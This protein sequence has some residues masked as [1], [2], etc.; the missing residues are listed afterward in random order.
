MKN[1]LYRI[2]SVMLMVTLA[3]GATQAQT[4][5]KNAAHKSQPKAA[6]QAKQQSKNNRVHVLPAKSVAK[7]PF[8]KAAK[9][10]VAKNLNPKKSAPAYAAAN[11]VPAING[12]CIFASDW[13]QDNPAPGL[14]ELPRNASASA[15]L[16]IS[17][18]SGSYG[19]VEVDGY[20]YSTDYLDYGFLAFAVLTVYDMETGEA[21]ASNYPSSLDCLSMAQAKDPVSGTIYGITYNSDAT[22]VQLSTLEY[23]EDATVTVTK[24]ADLDGHWSCMGI[25]SNSQIYAVRYEYTTGVTNS[26]LCK[27]DKSSGTVTEVGACGVDSEYLGGATIDPKTNRMYWAV[28]P[29]DE[30]GNLYE[31]NL[32]TGAATK[33]YQFNNDAE[34]VSLYIPAPAAEPGA[35]A[36]CSNVAANFLNGGLSGNI[37][38]TA[39]ATLFD[40]SAA[41]GNVTIHVLANDQE[42]ATQ[43]AAVGAEVTIPVTM[44]QAGNYNFVVYASNT[45]GDGPK[46]KIKNVFVGTDTPAATTATLAYEN[47][48]MNVS[49]TAV[50]SSVNGGYIDLSSLTYTV[51]DASGNVK[52]SNLTGTSWSEDYAMPDN[53]EVVYYTVTVV[54]G[55]I[56]S[57]PAQTNTVTVG[58]AVPPYTSNFGQDGL[59][60]WTVIDANGDGT[61]W[62][63][64][65]NEATIGYNA[66]LAM[67]DWLISVP[68]KLEAGKSYAV[69]F[70]ANSYA[71]SYPERLEV[72]YGTTPT[73]SGMTNSLIAA[74]D[75]ATAEPMALDAALVPAADG[76]YYIGIH[77]ISD[78]DEWT[79][80]VGNLTIE[81]GI[82]GTAPGAP[83]DL[84]VTPDASG[85]L[86]AA[87]SFKAPALTMAGNTLTELSKIEVYRD[88]TL[89]N[90]FDNPTIGGALSCE[91]N[92]LTTDGSHTYQVVGYN[93]SGAG[94]KA[95]ATV[96]IGFAEPADM[97]TV[98]ISRTDVE[99]EVLLS[100]DAVTTDIN[101]MAYPAGKVTYTVY[102]MDGYVRT[103]IANGV[104]ATSYTFQAVNAGEQTFVQYAVCAVVDEV[105]GALNLSELIPV[106]TPYDGLEESFANA[107]LNY[108]WATYSIDGGSFEIL[109]DESGIPAQDGDNGCVAVTAQYLDQGAELISGM[110]S[111]NKM[112]NPGLSFY[113]FDIATI[114]EDDNPDINEITVFVKAIDD[115]AYTTMF[116]GTVEDICAGSSDGWG[117][118]SVDLSQFANKVIE[119]KIQGIVQS[120]S[121]I[122]FD[123]IKVASTLDNDLSAASI[124][125]PSKVKAGGDFKVDVTVVNEGSSTAAEYSVELYKDEVLVNTYAGK[126]L[127]S[128]KR[129]VVS[130]DQTLSPLATEDVTY[131]AKV[132]FAADENETNN[133]TA[134]VTVTPVVSNYPTATDLS[135]QAED[136]GISLTWTAPDL[137]GGVA[138]PV[139]FDFEDA[140]SF[141]AEYGDFI[142]VDG[143]KSEVGGFE[144]M[145][146]PGIT[147]GTT[148]GSFWIWDTDEVGTGN[149]TFAAHSGTHYLFSLFRWDSGKSDEWAITPE[150]DGSAQDITFYAKSYSPGY[151]ES[152]EVY[153]ST[154][155]TETS[156]FV[157]IEGG[158][159]VPGDWTLYTVSVPE[160]AKRFAIRSVAEDSFMLMIDD[161]TCTPADAVAN[162][163]VEGYNI[164]RDGEKLN[165]APVADTNY[166][167]N[168][169][170]YGETYTYV[171][172]VVYKEKGESAASN[173][174]TI[175]QTGLDEVSAAVKV[176]VEGHNIVVSNADAVRVVAANG[177][178][179]YNGKGNDK[180]SVPV[181][182]GV[183]VVN[184]DK[185]VVKVIVK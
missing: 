67:D 27:I 99:G 55:G 52:A 137:T 16:L 153:Y 64:N 33:L 89:I 80:Y 13:T 82:Y 91:D 17:G 129:Q 30:T 139:T 29:A 63:V 115:E 96:Y 68:V 69:S 169:V 163:E 106:G 18:I 109:T 46:T 86:K 150:L 34:Y 147:A 37:T 61:S 105:E 12:V 44:A 50:N 117:R 84:V 72:K 158:G 148:L 118:V 78:A 70:D 160:G 102:A 145:D 176:A 22:G 39:P 116:N 60:G 42:I 5:K 108:D 65:G 141:T 131:Y 155:S 90:T 74:T 135:A 53:L 144:N 177:A 23:S 24:I 172:T 79:L 175:T 126:D 28:S 138:E 166:L 140:D 62:S 26:T 112:V 136:N 76:I 36:G 133:Q 156:D 185:Q 146:L 57:A 132:V 171:V 119:F 87:I 170:V 173:T 73:V 149:D 104:T 134:N 111:L 167:D 113:T 20:F 184:A 85:A 1:I 40:G 8:K 97:Q 7:A 14:Y 151:P 95:S 103:A 2:F 142:F 11:D 125:A 21:I 25:D 143:D 66:S 35:P 71:A 4:L 183:Y 54:A 168:T 19:G 94:V 100:W 6:L 77:G 123:N 121:Y 10:T 107:T 51:K 154:G 162:L 122:P 130:F 9:T 81:A 47:G 152:I 114:A 127:A 83:S 174:A 93:S 179:I 157:K 128:G 182:A 159:T 48:K 164:Y 31:V 101:G 49:W 15:D 120:Y 180:V 56:E 181:S 88:G 43:T 110:V 124:T 58:A 45:A 75:I 98:N 178:V 161:L 59:T 92:T 165:D 3:A 32:T 38:L 41:S